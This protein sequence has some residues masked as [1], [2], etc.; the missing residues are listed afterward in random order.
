MISFIVPINYNRIDRLLG[1]EF[2][3]KKFYFK[4]NYE[5]IVSEQSEN[6]VFLPGQVRNL[7]FKQ[8]IG[9]II[10]FLDADVRFRE[11]IDFVE[12]LKNTKIPAHI[13]WN[14]LIEVTEDSDFNLVEITKVKSSGSRGFIFAVEREYF[15]SYNGFSNLLF[16]WGKDDDIN[17]IRSGSRKYGNPIYHVW[18]KSRNKKYLRHNTEICN[19]IRE[20]KI[21]NNKDGLI[22]TIADISCLEERL[23][24]KHFLVSNIR[25]IEDYEYKDLIFKEKEN[26]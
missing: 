17:A 22:Q 10:V 3:I 5:I 14:G 15:K 16:D 9:D 2:N 13:C 23:N 20:K 7:G 8:S 18:H 24:Y 26:D 1:L 11:H 25:V 21:E 6:E 4:D 12:I 19:M